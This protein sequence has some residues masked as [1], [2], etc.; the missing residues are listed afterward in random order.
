MKFGHLSALTLLCLSATL[1]TGCSSSFDPADS[2]PVTLSTGTISGTTFGG[3]QPISGAQVYLF[4]AS[5]TANAGP[6]IAPA[7]ANKSTNLLTSGDGSDTD[8]YYVLTDANGKFSV[9]GHTTACTAG[10]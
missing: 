2:P 3:R 4:Q 5:T 8:G 6:G 10:D 9:N 7:T 1:I